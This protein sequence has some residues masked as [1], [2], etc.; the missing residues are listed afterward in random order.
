M[1]F[2]RNFHQ[3]FL[4][5]A[6]LLSEM[7]HSACPYGG[8]EKSTCGGYPSLFSNFDS[9]PRNV[10]KLQ[11]TLQNY[12]YAFDDQSSGGTSKI[13]DGAEK[14]ASYPYLY[15]PVWNQNSGFN[16]S[17]Y[18][19]FLEFEIGEPL[20]NNLSESVKNPGFAGFGV[21]VYDSSSA[22]YW[23]NRYGGYPYFYFDYFCGGDF[24]ELTLEIHD[25]HD[26]CDSREPNRQPIR[27]AGVVWH[28]HFPSTGTVWRRAGISLDSLTI[29]TSSDV[30]SPLPL[31]RTR[32]A[33]LLFKV[34]GGKG[35]KGKIAIDN[36][37]FGDGSKVNTAIPDVKSVIRNEITALYKNGMI[38]CMSTM[39]FGNSNVEAK[40]YSLEGKLA[41]AG[42]FEMQSSHELKMQIPGITSGRYLL[43]L[44]TDGRIQGNYTAIP[45]IIN[46]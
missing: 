7:V 34:Y 17:G 26:V 9:K 32:L 33:K 42:M 3:A 1:R 12:Y 13:L 23:D 6:F 15:V 29:H 4:L 45:V 37:Y 18:G 22:S 39:S 40:L 31:D 46:K 20:V 35:E 43:C 11:G 8:L 24:Q 28:K 38:L 36:L 16:D 44:K 2:G 25:Y 19:L 21:H 10:T 30:K 27:G 14:I 5:A 41:F